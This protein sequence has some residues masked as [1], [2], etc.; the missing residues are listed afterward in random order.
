MNISD[1][2]TY[3]L[4]EELKKREGIAPILVGPH[5]PY[6]IEVGKDRENKYNSMPDAETGPATI[7]VV[8]D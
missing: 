1:F 5:D 8:I 7:L 2:K 4:V 6:Y 3:E